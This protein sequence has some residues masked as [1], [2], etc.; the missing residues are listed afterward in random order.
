MTVRRAKVRFNYRDYCLLP[1]DK[2]YELIDGELY[3]APAPGT[4]HQTI[5]RDLGVLLWDF[6]RENRLGQVW[7]APFDV[8]LSDEDVVQP[9]VLFVSQQ[10]QGIISERGCEGPPDL[11]VEVLSPSNQGRDRELKRKVYARY[12]VREFWLV[13]PTAGTIQVM[14]LETEDFRSLGVYTQG[15]EVRSQVIPGLTLPVSHVFPAE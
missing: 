7:F 9:D 8:I 3:M 6:V 10:R 5:S 14:G 2:R 15:G 11:V 12:G 13:D 1:E 4:R